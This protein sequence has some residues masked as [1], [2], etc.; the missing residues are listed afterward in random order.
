MKEEGYMKRSLIF[1]ILLFISV[2]GFAQQIRITGGIPA[3]TDR[4]LYQLQVGAFRLFSNAEGAYERL[5]NASLNP[6][7]E[8][9]LDLTRVLIIGIRAADV[10]AYIERIR[11][12]GFTEVYIKR[13]TGNRPAAELPVRPVVPPTIVNEPEIPTA[14][15]QTVVNDEPEDIPIEIVLEEPKEAPPPE[16]KTDI[17]V[18]EILTEYTTETDFNLA[19]RFN[20]KGEIK[21]ASGS[22]GGIDILCKGLNGEWL[23]TTYNQGGWFYDLN[24]V[25]REMVNGWQ[26]DT[27]NG[28][29]L[30]IIPEFIY[31]E[32]FQYLQLRHVLYNPNV[33]AVTGQR[34]G[35]SADVMIHRNDYASVEH[36]YYG[37]YISDSQAAPSFGLMFIC[38]AE[39]DITPVDTLWIGEYYNGAHLDHI[40]EDRRIDVPYSDSAIGFSYQ[41]IDLGPFQAKEFIIRFAHIQ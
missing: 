8:K 16:N 14:A 27:D 28:V 15:L 7:Y 33:F 10:P 26:E 37:A 20:N 11:N 38:L 13:D 32:G 18:I 12:A 41:N 2:L 36:K 5:R 23:W 19:Y 34:F 9:Y 39:D 35:A 22:N 40:Y 24:G 21:G 4:N 6:I 1:T 30:T 25:K 3:A 29:E 17:S 31:Y